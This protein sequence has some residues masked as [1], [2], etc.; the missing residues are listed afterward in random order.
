MSS[1]PC[2]SSG[3]CL[4]TERARRTTE[5]IVADPSTVL[6]ASDFD[7]T[8]SPIVP[9][10]DTAELHPSARAA[11]AR[12]APLL[13]Q[14]AIVTGR[15]VR[16]VR[17]L[18]RLDE[19]PGLERLVVLG[20]YG[21]ERW[22]ATTDSLTLPPDPPN[23]R[24]LLAELPG[25]LADAGGAEARIEDK[26]RAVGV[27]TRQT[28]DPMGLHARLGG[29]LRGLAERFGLV[30]EEGRNVWEIRPTGATKGGALRTLLS[31]TGAR[32]VVFCG[33]DLGDLPAFDAV[34]EAAE[35]G[36]AGLIV[37]ASSAEQPALERRADVLC[38]GP[39]GVA[40]W[41]ND[42]ADHLGAH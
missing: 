30:V 19:V 18:G 25:V 17:R 22:D 38:A 4:V 3:F 31:E 2:A 1:V 8:L 14:V 42:L 28:A 23:V 35:S 39:A 15:D 29:P 10:P 24:A 32:T 34:D 6:L 21:A 26:G 13:G 36:L 27:H 41:L 20:Q 37:V 11:L 7:G 33:D 5:A 16:T 40:A 9:D 12:L